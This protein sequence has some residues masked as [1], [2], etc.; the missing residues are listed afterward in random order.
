MRNSLVDVVAAALRVLDDQGLEGCS[1]RRVAAEL[2]VQPSAL[3]H[4]VPDKQTLL[5][6]MADE[7]VAGVG[8]RARR[9]A[10][11]GA[12]AATPSKLGSAKMRPLAAGL[13]SAAH[14]QARQAVARR[15]C[16][17]LR[18]ATLKIRDGAD[19][20]ATAAAFRMGASALE[21][22]LAEL[23]GRDGA[24]TL[25]IYTF[26]QAQQTQM[27]RQ[28]A[29]FG[30]LVGVSGSS[31]GATAVS[32]EQGAR[33]GADGLDE[34]FTRGLEVILTGLAALA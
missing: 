20:V 3:Y 24:R 2:G 9:G 32:A 21:D 19:V 26:G 8:E 10:A 15:M 6:L 18:D 31:A 22:E 13:D 27:H 30:V 16:E 33:P 11:A 28:A 29:A 12:T 34:A 5:A 23:V 14:A 25:L 17:E 1:M 7:I 4:H